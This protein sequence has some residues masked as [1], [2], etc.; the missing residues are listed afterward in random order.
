MPPKRREYSIR[1]WRLRF[2]ELWRFSRFFCICNKRKCRL[3]ILK[4]L[5]CPLWNVLQLCTQGTVCGFRKCTYIKIFSYE[6]HYKSSDI[7]IQISWT[8][9]RKN[10]VHSFMHFYIY[11]LFIF[12]LLLSSILLSY[13]I[14]LLKLRFRNFSPYNH[15]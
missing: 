9:G 12:E 11:I 14:V 6:Y 10:L 8:V 5:S 7:C 3:S 13:T 4:I 2:S 1:R 15:L